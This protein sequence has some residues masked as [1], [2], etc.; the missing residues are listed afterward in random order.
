MPFENPQSI[1]ES[2]SDRIRVQAKDCGFELVGI[3]SAVT[4]AGLNDFLDWLNHGYAGEMQYLPLRKEAYGHPKSVMKNVK[5]VIMLGLNYRTS[6][7]AK[8]SNKDG[9]VSRYAWGKRDY[10]E[11]IKEKLNR[12]ADA[13]H[14]LHPD[15]RTRSVVDTAPLLERD[16]ARLAGLGWFGKN[17]MLIDKT[18]G[19][20]FFL[21][22]ILT[23]LE[24]EPDDP[25]ST[26]HCGSCTRCLDICPTDAFVDPYV[27]DATKCISYLT[28]ELKENIPRELRDGMGH[29]L[30]GC[31]LCQEV[32]PWN[33]KAP[34]SSEA[35]F[36]PEES[37]YPA[38]ALR[39]LSM[40]EEEFHALFSKTPLER[41]GYRGLRRNAAIVL[42]NHEPSAESVS[43]L[44]A[45]L[46]DQDP[47]IRE[48]VAWSLGKLGTS[49]ARQALKNRM[50][51]ET[52][53]RV[54][55]EIGF[56]IESEIPG[57]SKF[58]GI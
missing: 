41:P 3:A 12:L 43:A 13:L 37:L 32:C 7:P 15:C 58:S 55:K 21:G 6:E 49:A 19:S 2:L 53:E 48:S 18:I 52:T 26:S 27:L 24:L 11:V 20:W 8:T 38:D 10:H 30:F 1:T 29:W 39:F 14:Q 5:S 34:I 33:R 40:S 17:T 44:I 57:I 25:H 4:P 22:A 46:D 23:D 36:F 28:I 56:A 47:V 9:F 54:R 31:D 45:V 16:F 42:G 50:K 35:D 51:V